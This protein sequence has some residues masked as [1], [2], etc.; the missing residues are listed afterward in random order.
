MKRKKRVTGR[1]KP[2]RGKIAS[3]SRIAG[4]ETANRRATGKKMAGLKVAG[5]K[6]AGRR[7]AGLQASGNQASGDEV[8]QAWATAAYGA[9][10]RPRK[11]RITLFLDADVLA[12][13]KESGRRYQTRINRALWEVMKREKK[14]AAE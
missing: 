2:A 12:W 4:S 14:E 9:W 11:K 1:R 10:R 7:I 3:G 5:R 13:F 6:V 8:L